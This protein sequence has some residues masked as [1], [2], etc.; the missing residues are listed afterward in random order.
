MK[1]L[2]CGI[3]SLLLFVGCNDGGSGDS[4]VTT[5]Q[6]SGGGGDN[7]DDVPVNPSPKPTPTNYL[8]NGKEPSDYYR[9]FI[10]TLRGD[11]EKGFDH[12]RLAPDGF[13]IHVGWDD[14]GKRIVADIDLYLER[15]GVYVLDYQQFVPIYN[16]GSS[17]SYTYSTNH[18]KYL[19]KRIKG[20]WRVQDD[21]VVL[22]GFA[23]GSAITYNERP[24]I[25]FEYT[26]NIGTE[27]LVG[28]QD[29]FYMVFSNHGLKSEEELCGNPYDLGIFSKYEKFANFSET[30][31]VTGLQAENINAK[32]LNRTVDKMD[33]QIILTKENNFEIRFKFKTENGDVVKVERGQWLNLDG[34]LKLGDLAN[35]SI[36]DGIVL[37][38]FTRDYEADIDHHGKIRIDE[39]DFKGKQYPLFQREGYLH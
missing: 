38:T 16:E 9:Q 8:I 6:V 26:E 15:D 37:I 4:G 29:I 22:A 35:L 23:V 3:L 5:E 25:L 7:I 2:I 13:Q 33:L 36:V 18:P 24:S 12:K 10:Y 17:N 32:D 30:G 34:L 14:E 39:L 28:V 31:W 20:D 21:K 19:E 27:E 1:N 11:C